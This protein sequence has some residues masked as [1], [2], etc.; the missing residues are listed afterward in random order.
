LIFTVGHGARSAEELIAILQD[1][2]I[3]ILV[4]VRA[5]PASRRHP[6]FS[7]EP[8]RAALA[9][10]GMAYQWEG[11]ALG[12][13]RKSYVDH[14]HTEEFRRS[15]GALGEM[16]GRVCLL[17]AE[18]NPENC[19]RWHIADWLVAQGQPVLHLGK[20]GESSEHRPHPQARLL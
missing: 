4:D 17:C 16:N 9:D 2:R 11:H 14:M 6:Q 20:K 12:G 1:A 13:M 5:Y 8:L 18:A 15:A 10:A 7:K 19:H 3:D